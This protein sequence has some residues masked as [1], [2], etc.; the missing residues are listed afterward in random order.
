M[1]LTAEEEQ[2]LIDLFTRRMIRHRQAQARYRT[3]LGKEEIARQNK[4]YYE[5]QRVLFN[6]VKHKL[7]VPQTPTATIL[8]VATRKPQKIDGRSKEARKAKAMGVVPGEIKPSFQK[9]DYALS[10]NAKRDYMSKADI[11]HRLFTQQSLPPKLK[12]ELQKLLND[13]QNLNEK[14]ILQEM[15]YLKNDNADD[16]ITRLREKYPRDSSFKS[17]VTVLSVIA[18]HLQTAKEAHQKFSRTGMFTNKKVQEAREENIIAEEDEGK[19]IDLDDASIMENVEK[20]KA[21]DDILIYC[22]YTLFPARRLEYRTMRI[23]TET[24]PKKLTDDN[25]V[26][27]SKPKQFVFNDYK[28]NRTF[29]QQV[30]N[31]DNDYL[32]EVI[33]IAIQEKKLKSGDYLFSLARD[34]RE[35]I[36]QSAFSAKVSNTFKKVYGVPISIRFLR[37]SHSTHFHK[38]NPSVAAMREHAAM[39]AHSLEE[40]LRY[41]KKK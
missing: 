18:S 27:L 24:N 3:K 32:S 8:D 37:M 10:D 9:R 23:T 38:T 33:D 22:L 2:Q 1:A 14:F 34:K 36:N 15:P 13:N 6:N 28:T 39:M 20:L 7:T 11:L 35:A 17:Y 26:I 29:G 40:S 5:K 4:E 31:V 30:F 12:A 25:Y 16:S 19:I 21:I 41:K